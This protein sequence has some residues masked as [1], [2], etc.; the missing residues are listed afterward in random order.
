M[1]NILITGASTGIGYHTT[2][3]FLE[4][5]YGVLGSVRKKEDAD[6]L[7][8]DFGDHFHPLIFDVNDQEGINRAVEEAQQILSGKGLACL[9]NNAGI[10]VSGPLQHLSVEELQQQFDTN[11]FGVLR[12]SQAF[13]PFLGAQIPAKYPA[14]K[15]VNIS[16]VSGFVTAPFMGAY[17]MSKYAL[18]SMSDAFRRE[19][20]IYDIDVVVIEPAAVSTDIWSKAKS[21]DPKFLDTDYGTILKNWDRMVD[22]SEK[23]GVPPDDVAQKIYTSVVAKKPS[24]RYIVAK[25]KMVMKLVK[26]VFSDRFLDKQLTKSFK[27]KVKEKD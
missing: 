12:V 9:V 21:L 7:K 20:S 23:N 4:K 2:K 8:N 22:N 10:V 24:T 25:K 18:E 6:R 1:Q 3:L 5:G 13:L 19:L 11:V 17:A 27:R 15:I 16:S 26:Y 14:G